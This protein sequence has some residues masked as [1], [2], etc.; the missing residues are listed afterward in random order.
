MSRTNET[1]NVAASTYSTTRRAERGDQ[2]AGRRRAEQRRATLGALEDGVRLG[3]RPLV[4]ADELGQ[5]EPLRREVRREEQPISATRTSSSGKLSTP[6]ACR[7]GIDASNGVRTK[8]ETT[9][10]RR[11]PQREM[12]VPQ[13]MPRMRD[14][15]ELDREHDAHAR[16]GARRLEDEPGQRE[17]RHLRAE[18]GHDDARDE[19]ADAPCAEDAHAATREACTRRS[20]APSDDE[21]RDGDEAHRHGLRRGERHQH[22]LRPEGVEDRP[23]AED[24]ERLREAEEHHVHGHHARPEP[25]PARAAS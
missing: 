4:V 19:R 7:I 17:E 22:G 25:R 1:K 11:A 6:S 3:D 8:S 23:D 14:G 10:T 24:A 13:G 5:D 9:I 20:L 18:R 2:H 16:R 15:S 21:A 12:T